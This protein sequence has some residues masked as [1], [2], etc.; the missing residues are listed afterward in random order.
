[1]LSNP[2]VMSFCMPGEFPDRLGNILSLNSGQMIPMKA[3]VKPTNSIQYT[4]K[5]IRSTGI[6]LRS[7]T[8]TSVPELKIS[9]RHLQCKTFTSLIQEQQVPYCFPRPNCYLQGMRTKLFWYLRSIFK[10]DDIRRTCERW[11]KTLL[12][13]DSSFCLSSFFVHELVKSLSASDVSWNI[14]PK[15]SEIQETRQRN[16]TNSS[17]SVS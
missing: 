9:L 7:I 12:G 1:M 5:V 11:S 14:H 13:S 4:R 6:S 17:G 16:R 8:T 3:T 10:Y 15:F 2:V